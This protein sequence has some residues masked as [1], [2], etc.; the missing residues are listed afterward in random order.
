VRAKLRLMV[1]RILRKYKYP[2]DQQEKAIALVLQQAEA[3][4]ERWA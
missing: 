3:L 1:K 2:P 4:S